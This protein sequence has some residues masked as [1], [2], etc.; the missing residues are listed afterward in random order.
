MPVAEGYPGTHAQAIDPGAGTVPLPRRQIRS[1]TFPGLLVLYL[2]YAVVAKICHID[3][4]IIA[5]SKH[6]HA[7][8]VVKP[9]RCAGTIREARISF[10]SYSGVS[11]VFPAKRVTSPVD[12]TI[13]R[14]QW[15]LKSAT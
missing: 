13:L 14:M 5:G 2:P 6:G 12:M 15:L 1:S 3:T 9:C 10:R 8:G 7:G 4:V 11:V